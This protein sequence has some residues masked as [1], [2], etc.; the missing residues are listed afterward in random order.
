MKN[1]YIKEEKGKMVYL[2]GKG[3]SR[4]TILIN[5]YN[6]KLMD[7]N[8]GDLL[9]I[10]TLTNRII[11]YEITKKYMNKQVYGSNP[12]KLIRSNTYYYSGGLSKSYHGIFF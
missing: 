3:N 10:L 8:S 5:G 1:Q 2:H 11:F 9:L 4:K 7:L 12:G 6:L